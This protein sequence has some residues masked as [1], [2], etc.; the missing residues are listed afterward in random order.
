MNGSSPN[1]KGIEKWAF[2]FNSYQKFLEHLTF[3]NR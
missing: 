3:S 1:L 2:I